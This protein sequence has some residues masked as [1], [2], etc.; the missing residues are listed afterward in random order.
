MVLIERCASF[1]L[2]VRYITDAHARKYIVCDKPTSERL[3][4]RDCSIHE[5]VTLTVMDSRQE[6]K[7]NVYARSE[8]CSC[9]DRD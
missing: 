9:A 1:E 3:Q 2:K 6:I 8:I 4:P 7:V 5:K